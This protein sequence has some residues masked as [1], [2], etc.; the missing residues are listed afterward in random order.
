MSCRVA[1]PRMATDGLITLPSSLEAAHFDRAVRLLHPS[2]RSCGCRTGQGG[3][4]VLLRL[5]QAQ[6]FGAAIV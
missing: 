1:M 4:A 5:L 6:A 2:Y 3:M